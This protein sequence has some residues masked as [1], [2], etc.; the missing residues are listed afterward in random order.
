MSTVRCSGP[1]DPPQTTTNVV[2]IKR[3]RKLVSLAAGVGSMIIG[4]LRGCLPLTNPELRIMKLSVWGPDMGQQL[5]DTQSHTLSVVFPVGQAN[6]T[7]PG[8]NS[9]WTDDGTAG[10]VR[11]QIHLTPCFEYRNFWFQTGVPGSTVVATFGLAN[12]TTAD[13]IIVD[14]TLQYRT[15]VQTCPALDHLNDLRRL[16]KAD[17]VEKLRL[18]D[19]I[20]TG[21]SPPYEGDTVQ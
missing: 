11:A 3:I 20:D 8:D 4:D 18:I 13:T 5:T 7:N 12:E 19:S 10:S 9:V 16:G 2:G 21:S 1:L 6:N 17:Y 14:V 15:A